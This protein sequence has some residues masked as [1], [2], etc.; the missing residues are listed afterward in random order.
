MKYGAMSTRKLRQ[1]LLDQGIVEIR[2]GDKVVKTKRAPKAY[3]IAALRNGK[4]YEVSG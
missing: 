1:L 3:C 2:L 4:L